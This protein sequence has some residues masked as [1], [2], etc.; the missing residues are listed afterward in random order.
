M[1]VEEALAILDK[2]CYKGVWK[3]TVAMSLTTG[4]AG[5]S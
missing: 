5:R 4:T 3:A 2:L 1:T